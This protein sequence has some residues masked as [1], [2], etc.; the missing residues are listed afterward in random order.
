LLC[1]ER[2]PRPGVVVPAIVVDDA[3]TIALVEAPSTIPAVSAE[4]LVAEVSASVDVAVSVVVAAGDGSA[5]LAAPGVAGAGALTEAEPSAVLPPPSGARISGV[6]V[7]AVVVADDGTTKLVEVLSS[8][9]VEVATELVEEMSGVGNVEVDTIGVVDDDDV[10]SDDD[11]IST[12]TGGVVVEAEGDDV[13]TDE[14]PVSGEA[15]S[16]DEIAMTVEVPASTGTAPSAVDEVPTGALTSGVVLAAPS[17]EVEF[18]A[19]RAA[20]KPAE[21]VT[22]TIVSAISAARRDFIA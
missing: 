19:V 16:G 8:V 4:E 10:A 9:G 13:A 1:S 11:A 18:G 14:V 12:G 5:A 15:L 7:S 21:R 20:A 22:N 17:V 6:D 2:T 3:R